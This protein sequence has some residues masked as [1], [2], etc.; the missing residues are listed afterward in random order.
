MDSV[1]TPQVYRCS[2]VNKTHLWC[3]RIAELLFFLYKSNL[4]LRQ[5]I[6][7]IIKYRVMIRRVVYGVRAS[8]FALSLYYAP[9]FY[10]V[11]LWN[12]WW[13]LARLFS[14]LKCGVCQC[15]VCVCVCFSADMRL[16][17]SARRVNHHINIKWCAPHRDTISSLCANIK[18]FW[19]NHNNHNNNSDRLTENYINECECLCHEKHI[20]IVVYAPLPV[21]SFALWHVR[22][23]IFPILCVLCHLARSNYMRKL[24]IR[25][26]I[27]I[28]MKMCC[29]NCYYCLWNFWI[30]LKWIGYDAMGIICLC[31][32]T[33]FRSPSESSYTHM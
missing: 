16:C 9:L 4:W 7:N 19:C 28:V 33:P 29:T 18:L 25:S 24:C 14:L 15:I 5:L 26:T 22:E 2:F 30:V 3:R 23:R 12:K 21:P 13:L 8:P 1:L 17:V 31:P 32:S 20:G 27:G 6:F 10:C 11:Y